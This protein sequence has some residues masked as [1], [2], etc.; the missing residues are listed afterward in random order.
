MEN[1]AGNFFRLIREICAEQGINVK[2][3]CC[4]WVFMLERGKKRAYIIGYTF[5][6]DNGAAQ[7]VCTDKS[8]A[9]EIMEHF[10][11]PCVRH[12]YVPSPEQYEYYTE[13]QRRGQTDGLLDRY[14]ELVCKPNRGTGGENI[15]FVRTRDR[16]ESAAARI[17][18]KSEAMAVSPYMEIEREF[19]VIWLDGRAEL[20]YEKLRP[21]ITGDGTSTT[22]QLMRAC[23]AEVRADALDPELDLQTV[24]A[25]GQVV[26]LSRK[27]NL[28][29]GAR[30]RT[31][32]DSEIPPE[33]VRLAERAAQAL[34][35][36]FASV[37]VVRGT[38]GDH[39]VI[40]VNSGVMMEH[41]SAQS[42]ENY[43]EAK[44]IYTKA[45]LSML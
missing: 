42:A 4:D 39:R 1:S 3:F 29:L 40:E 36:R 20:V 18:A 44:R 11:I 32:K 41:F 26:Y 16:L 25:A 33:A 31:L 45:I 34:G 38:D 37:D 6:L 21:S 8:A 2:S 43:A 24:P 22:A 15:F 12:F 9:S 27:H 7:A 13:E 14:G 28:G 5:G 10:E 35:L 23:A 19:R 17:F 30:A